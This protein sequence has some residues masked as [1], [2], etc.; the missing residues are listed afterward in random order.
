MSPRLVF[1]VFIAL[2]AV[3]TAVWA[4]ALLRSRRGPA[5][6]AIE[7]AEDRLRLRLLFVFAVIF[8]GV[9]ALSL[10]GYPYPRFRAR[11]LGAPADTVSVIAMQWAWSMSRDTV[12]AGVPV[13][14]VVRSR[15]VNHGFGIYAPDG[16]LVVQVQAMPGYANRLIYRFDRAGRYTVRCLEYCGT[17]HH[18]MLSALTVR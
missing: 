13:E 16:T 11:A 6:E 3:W 8:L 14:F 1:W 12:P 15:D 5:F 18:A 17:V 9:F 7:P 4:L 2:G 10:P